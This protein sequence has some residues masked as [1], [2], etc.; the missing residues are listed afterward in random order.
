M[1][2]RHSKR[3]SVVDG[4]VLEPEWDQVPQT[5]GSFNQD[6]LAR[7]SQAQAEHAHTARPTPQLPHS[8]SYSPEHPTRSPSLKWGASTVSA[9]PRQPTNGRYY[10]SALSDEDKTAL[11]IGDLNHN[12]REWTGDMLVQYHVSRIE[13]VPYIEERQEII[14]EILDEKRGSERFVLNWARQA[15]RFVCSP[16]SKLQM[17][18]EVNTHNEQTR[19]EA[20]RSM[21]DLRAASTPN[22]L[23]SPTSPTSS[24]SPTP[25]TS[26]GGFP[27]PEG[28]AQN[29]RQ[30]TYNGTSS[31]GDRLSRQSTNTYTMQ[32]P[33]TSDSSRDSTR[34]RARAPD[35]R[36][37]VRR[38]DRNT[39]RVRS[40]LASEA[41][42]Y[43]AKA[44][45][46]FDAFLAPHASGKGE[47]HRDSIH[48]QKEQPRNFSRRL[49]KMPSMP[50]LKK[51]ASQA[52]SLG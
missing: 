40:S 50:Q 30:T 27:F 43:V 46:T 29:N 20:S 49:S 47:T 45:L 51:R 4:K 52:F 48:I 38:A 25:S 15:K 37:L 10:S 17:F 24:A 36:P 2:L 3:P 8:Q 26:G 41:A 11:A 16:L 19:D 31:I 18:K 13:L 34:N 12:L 35:G 28:D 5:Y 14:A 21:V 6:T 1:P 7:I 42:S 22:L 44:D 33:H 9:S 32:S 39:S 23:L